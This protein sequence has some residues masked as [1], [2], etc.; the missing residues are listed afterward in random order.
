MFGKLLGKALALPLRVLDVPFAV[1]DK[2]T[3]DPSMGQPEIRPFRSAANAVE[4]GV[5]D[6]IDG[7]ER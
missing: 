2:V 3:G 1:I 6:A 7:E 5:E 4:Q